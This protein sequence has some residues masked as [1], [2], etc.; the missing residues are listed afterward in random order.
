MEDI[1]LEWIG[2]K[3]ALLG[4][5]LGMQLLFEKSEEHGT[6]TGLNVLPGT[7]RKITGQVK[8]PHMGWNK[9]RINQNHK[10]FQNISD[11][12][13]YFVHSY[14]ADTFGDV[15]LATTWYSGEIPV[16]V[17]K[18]NVLGMQFHPEK[19]G[20]VGMRLLSNWAKLVKA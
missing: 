15:V 20:P 7:I 3:R 17:G 14:F 16:I 19:S 12:Y 9:L 2:E 11:G 4:I 6:H 5:C 18:E 13:V 10:L 1:I 8:V